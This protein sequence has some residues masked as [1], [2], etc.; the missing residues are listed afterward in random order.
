MTRSFL[1]ARSA[2]ATA[3]KDIELDEDDIRDIRKDVC[4]YGFST[5]EEEWAHIAR[6]LDSMGAASLQDFT[7]LAKATK[8]HVPSA[9][10][11][12]SILED[13]VVGAPRATEAPCISKA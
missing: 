8:K 7:R 11:P 13:S 6:M 10:S 2:A 9:G 12:Q 4:M 1:N 5:T 3:A